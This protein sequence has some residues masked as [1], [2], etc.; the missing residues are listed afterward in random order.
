MTVDSSR[1]SSERDLLRERVER[2]WVQA[3]ECS[4]QL[5][6]GDWQS[7]ACLGLKSAIWARLEV[8]VVE[9]EAICKLKS[10]LVPV[11]RMQLEGSTDAV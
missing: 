6:S 1:R 11:P 5:P 9:L 10:Q 8:P 7:P 4:L 2:L 3:Q